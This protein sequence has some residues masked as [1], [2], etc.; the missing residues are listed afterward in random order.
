MNMPRLTMNRIHARA[1][2][3]ERLTMVTAYDHPTA[4][5]V[6]AAGVDMILVGDSAAMVVLGHESTTRA[7]LEMQVLFTDAVSRGSSRALVIGDMPFGSYEASNELAITSACT[8]TGAGGAHAVKLEGGGTMIDRVAA[9]TGVG[10]DVVGHLGLTPQ[11]ASSLGGYRVQAREDSGARALLADAR[12]LQDAGACMLVLE[13][14][15]EHVAAVVTRELNIPTI[16]IGAGAVT[17]GQVLV[18]HDLLGITPDPLPRFVRRF[19][20]VGTDIQTAVSRYVHAV[21]DGS[22]P[23]AEHEYAMKAGEREL[24]ESATDEPLHTDIALRTA[25]V[26]ADT[27]CEAM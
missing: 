20:D 12:A 1:A 18:L 5:L 15:P 6:D 24:F 8:L 3:G 27:R 22:F 13:C 11:R 9:I 19:G 14:I 10:I 26:S 17:S 4:R 16:G 21:R 23:A 25:Q 2:D 7:T